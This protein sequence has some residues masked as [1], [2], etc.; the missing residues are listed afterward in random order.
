MAGLRIQIDLGGPVPITRQIVDQVRTRLVDG[1]LAPGDPL[2]SV[3]RLAVDLGVHF[4]TVADAYR[5]LAEE[6][7]LDVAQ[8]RSVRVRARETPAAGP[9]TR[10]AFRQRLQLLV[11]EARSQGLS[12]SVVAREL[13]ATA[14]HLKS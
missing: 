11:A 8:G 13:T 12:A 1:A 9:E 2:P 5:V 4:N 6:G 14:E 7:W 10:Q 3:R